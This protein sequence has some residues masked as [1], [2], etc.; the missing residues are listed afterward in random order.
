M[1][2]RSSSSCAF[3]ALRSSLRRVPQTAQRNQTTRIA[4]SSRQLAPTRQ[5]VFGSSNARG[6]HLSTAF[7]KG[8]TPES[9]DPPPK[10]STSAEPGAEPAPISIEDYHKLSDEYINELVR[11]LEVLQEEKGDMDCDYS[12]GLWKH[13]YR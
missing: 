12:V 3:R 5:N 1:L 2:P 13:V 6:F 8:L 7:S 11:K 4:A 9:P 10:S